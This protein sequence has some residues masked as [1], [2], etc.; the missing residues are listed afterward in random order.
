MQKKRVE[1]VGSGNGKNLYRKA[2]STTYDAMRLLAQTEGLIADPVYEGKA[3]R[4]LLELAEQGRFEAGARVCLLHLGGTPD[5][6]GYADTF[7]FIELKP[8]PGVSQCR[9]AE[10][11]DGE[12]G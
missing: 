3:L 8:I 7:D 1:I 10:I 12:G 9:T 4:G 2:D 6:H 5:I 11:K